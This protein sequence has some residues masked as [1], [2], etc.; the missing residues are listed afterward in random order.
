MKS[1]RACFHERVFKSQSEW[2]YKQTNEILKRRI[3]LWIP[4]LYASYSINSLFFQLF[5]WNSRHWTLRIKLAG[6]CL[7]RAKQDSRQWTNQMCPFP[8]LW[9]VWLTC[10]TP[11]RQLISANYISLAFKQLTRGMSEVLQF[12]FAAN[13]WIAQKRNGTLSSTSNRKQT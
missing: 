6:M 2:Q 9:D 4:F 1:G 8:F 13:I 5:E 7:Q 11:C 10:W 12:A 3:K